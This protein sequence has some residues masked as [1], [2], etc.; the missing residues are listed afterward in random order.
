M[1]K[2]MLPVQRNLKTK[3]DKDD[4]K[5]K[6]LRKSICHL[7]RKILF[8]FD[9]VFTVSEQAAGNSINYRVVNSCN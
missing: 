6:D 5:Q 7:S 3:N 8:M 9:A 1:H 2:L 4:R